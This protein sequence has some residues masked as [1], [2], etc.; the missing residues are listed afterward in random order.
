MFPAAFREI[1]RDFVELGEVIF[2]TATPRILW[3]SERRFLGTT[4][5]KRALPGSEVEIGLG[6]DTAQQSTASFRELK[7]ESVNYRSLV[8]SNLKIH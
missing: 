8:N 4:Q 5:K 2:H 7:S 6:K 3:D 1:Y